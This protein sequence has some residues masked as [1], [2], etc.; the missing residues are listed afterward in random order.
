[1]VAGANTFA[2][3]VLWVLS[4]VPHDTMEKRRAIYSVLLNRVAREH[5]S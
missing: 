4:I 5:D 1:M 2:P 3:V